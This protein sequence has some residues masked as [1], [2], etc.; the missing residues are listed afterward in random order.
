MQYTQAIAIAK[1]NRIHFNPTGS[2]K[3]LFKKRQE[4]IPELKL[5]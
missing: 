2:Y 4:F 3:K 1:E 5:K